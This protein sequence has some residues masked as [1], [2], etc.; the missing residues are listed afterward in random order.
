MVVFEHA[1][2]EQCAAAAAKRQR[3]A[4]AYHPT[5]VR[6]LLIAQTPPPDLDCDQVRYDNFEVRG[7]DPHGFDRDGDG[8][9][10]ET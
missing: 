5:H 4:E 9:G 1:T 7:S 6:F 3:A 2:A 10:C 8:I